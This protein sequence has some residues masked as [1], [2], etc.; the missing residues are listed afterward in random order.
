MQKAIDDTVAEFGGIDVLVNNAGFA[1]IGPVEGTS[2]GFEKYPAQRSGL[3]R[4]S[5]PDPQA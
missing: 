4:H 5:L 3:G 2:P 1:T